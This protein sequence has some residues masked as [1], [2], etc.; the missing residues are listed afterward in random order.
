MEATILNCLIL[1]Y[2]YGPP[3]GNE[4]A[5][6]VGRIFGVGVIFL[7]F[8]GLLAIGTRIITGWLLD[9]WPGG[10]RF[11]GWLRRIGTASI[12]FVTLT[13]LIYAGYRISTVA[14]ARMRYS[15]LHRMGHNKTSIN[16]AAPYGTQKP[17][18][19]IVLV[20]SEITSG[21][22][23]DWATM[24]ESHLPREWIADEVSNLELVCFLGP[25]E[26][27]TVESG[28]YR[29]QGH[30]PETTVRA[31]RRDLPATLIEATTGRTIA[32]T[33]LHGKP[34]RH[35]NNIETDA[36]VDGKWPDYQLLQDWLR[37]YV[38]QVST[39]KLL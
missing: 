33:V 8:A 22:K 29:L 38:L 18:Q 13:G 28:L 35:L 34:P 5:F 1:G 4:V 39:Q 14:A 37:P 11:V 21:Y 12:F 2:F 10:H 16:G 6:A 9:I 26:K 36:K 7:L 25:F 20:H 15:E 23:E 19:L 31:I 17:S 27:T 32:K 30:G 3:E 24:W